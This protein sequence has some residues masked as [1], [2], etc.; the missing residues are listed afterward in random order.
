M[1]VLEGEGLLSLGEQGATYFV[2]GPEGFT[3]DVVAGLKGRGVEE[4]RVRVE[5][6]GLGVV[7]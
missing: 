5:R 1:D 4:G 6:F 2:C 3:G 7:S